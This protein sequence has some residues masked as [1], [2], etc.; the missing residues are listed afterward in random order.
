MFDRFEISNLGRIRNIETGRVLKQF[1]NRN[2]Y[3]QVSVSLGGRNNKKI[4]K[5]HKAVAETFI[6][7]PDNKPI[8]NHKDGDKTNNNVDN[9]EW[10]TYSENIKHA[11]DT[12]LVTKT[13]KINLRKL[14][15]EDVRYIRESYIP[16]DKE[17]G[18]R[19]LAKKFDM[20]KETILDLI[21]YKTYKD[22]I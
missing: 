11:F 2:G 16:N 10:T 9:L 18:S 21:K 5:I 14:S 19:A 17:F 4:F 1:V 22:I 3:R 13:G 15:D 7:N 12:G 20:N 6:S 8:I